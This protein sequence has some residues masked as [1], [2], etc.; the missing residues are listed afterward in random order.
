MV[1][2]MKRVIA[3]SDERE[4]ARRSAHG[5]L[6]DR[7]AA[8]A[9]I[10]GIVA[11]SLETVEPW[12]D[13]HD[14]M[15][16]KIQLAAV[17]VM[18]CTAAVF[19]FTTWG[20]QHKLA[21]FTFGYLVCVA[22]YEAVVCHERAFGTTYSDGFVVF[23]AFYCVLIPTTVLHTGLIGLAVLLVTA[24]PEVLVTGEIGRLGTAAIGAAAAFAVLLS[25]RRI[26]NESWEREFAARRLQSD[27]VS[28]VSHE[29][30]NP[31][32][33]L[34]LWTEQLAAGRIA[35]EKDRSDCYQR[36]VQGTHRLTRLVEGLLRFGRMEGN[37]VRYEFDNIDPAEFVP[38]VSREF[39]RDGDLANHRIVVRVSGDTP[40]IKA[41]GDALRCVLWNLLDNAVKYSPGCEE[42]R[43][44]VGREDGH[45]VVR[46]SDRGLGIP[47]A[48]QP[49]IFEKFVRG[50][51][52]TINA[53]RGTGLGLTLAHNIMTAHGGK[54]RVQSKAGQGSTFTL[55]LP[56]VK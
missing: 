30:L 28:A 37:I 32:Q 40:L 45:A 56:L 26:A 52:A 41:D 20:A 51:A 5:Q 23:F 12:L 33:A 2:G 3:F 13:F 46:V 43:V 18:I 34:R 49:H 38:K 29:F 11:F 21:L 19:F 14:L 36:L 9:T 8:Q 15:A 27:F 48:E 16:V 1:A 54:I 10:V 53:I 25:G 47:D 55:L 24:V 31:L 50:E 22:G 42:V 17:C 44:D 39:E 4:S 6:L 7:R 35:N